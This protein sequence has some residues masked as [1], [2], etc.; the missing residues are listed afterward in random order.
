MDEILARAGSFHAVEPDVASALTIRMHKVDFP[1]NRHDD[2][3]AA[4]NRKTL[5]AIWRP[6]RSHADAGHYFGAVIDSDGRGRQFYSQPMADEPRRHAV[7]IA[8]HHDLRIPVYPRRHCQRGVESLGRQGPQQRCFK[9]P[10]VADAGGS[11]TDTAGVVGVIGRLQQRV[12]LVDRVHDGHWDTVVST[13]PPTLTFHAALFVAALVAW[14]AIPT[15]DTVVRPECDP[16]LIFLPG[17]S[18]QHLFNRAVEVV[19]ADLVHRDPAQAFQRKD[20][21]LQESL[22]PLGQK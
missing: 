21:P 20:V 15:F 19:V 14:P 18:E 22:P 6:C 7:L 4:H 13:K 8:A 16:P 10:I 17:A 9:R 12:E 2:K 11:V 1:A 5:F 3:A